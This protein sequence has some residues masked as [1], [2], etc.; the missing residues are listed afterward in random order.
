MDW[1]QW[2]VNGE[3]LTSSLLHISLQA[4]WLLKSFQG[5]S[6]LL[7]LQRVHGDLELWFGNP[8]SKLL[9][10][11]SA[12]AHQMMHLRPLPQMRFPARLAL[13]SSKGCPHGSLLGWMPSNQG[14]KLQLK[15]LP[16]VSIVAS[17]PGRHFSFNLPAVTQ[18]LFGIA[19]RR[20]LD[21]F[22][23]SLLSCAMRE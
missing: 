2:D 6:V 1:V 21:S 20:K 14:L 13:F 23:P 4:A 8:Y 16:T 17:T 19:A 12:G 5:L 18:Q 3:T 7:H 15:T 9:R 11:Q 10:S 22:M